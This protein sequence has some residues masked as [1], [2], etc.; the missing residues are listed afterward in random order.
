M[1]FLEN[2]KAFVYTKFQ[3]FNFYFKIDSKFS[4]VKLKY[5]IGFQNIL[6]L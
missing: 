1:I 3:A 4:A 5:F 2:K 6:F